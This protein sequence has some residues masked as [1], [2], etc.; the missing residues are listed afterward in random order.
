MRWA[1]PCLGVT[2]ESTQDLAAHVTYGTAD[3]GGVAWFSFRGFSTAASAGNWYNITDFQTFINALDDDESCPPL[4]MVT[5][6]L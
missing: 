5:Q 6:G 1:M 2:D 4:A 3:E